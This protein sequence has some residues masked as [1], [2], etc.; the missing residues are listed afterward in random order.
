MANGDG[1][2][3]AQPETK[4]RDVYVAAGIGAFLLGFGDLLINERSATVLKVGE[5]IRQYLVPSLTSSPLVAFLFLILLGVAVCFIHQPRSRV[6][7]FT[8][9]S[10]LF[11]LLAA[12]TPFNIPEGLDAPSRVSNDSFFSFIS[13]AHAQQS[14]EIATNRPKIEIDVEGVAATSPKTI[15][16]RD[17]RTAKIVAVETIT[18]RDF[19]LQRP[20]GSYIVEIEASGH[21]RTAARLEI[22]RGDEQRS[23]SLPV[24]PSKIPVAIQRLYRPRMMELQTEEE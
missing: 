11:A 14:A 22:E 13:S 24:V 7:G 15:V 9:D 23:Y 17:Q 12:I 16:V 19:V 1:V 4:A 3:T 18:G 20:P 8:R 5:V 2:R 6:D 10:S 21:R